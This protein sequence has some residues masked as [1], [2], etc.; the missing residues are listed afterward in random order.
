MDIADTDAQRR[1]WSAQ[2]DGSI[3]YDNTDLLSN[4]DNVLRVATILSEDD[5][6]ELFPL[7]N[8]VY[9]YHGFL[10]AIARWPAICG[11]F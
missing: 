5:W 3:A 11:D 8:E 9:T 4:E 6:N 7:A 2:G 10:G 1:M